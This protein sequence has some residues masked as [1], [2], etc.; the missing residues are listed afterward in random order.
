[1][2][3]CAVLLILTVILVVP[4]TY[5]NGGLRGMSGTKIS[6][7]SLFSTQIIFWLLMNGLEFGW[8]INI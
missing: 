3:S 6:H 7:Q 5:L 2:F 4:D 1:M 8:F